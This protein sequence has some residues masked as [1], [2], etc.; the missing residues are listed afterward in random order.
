MRL[1]GLGNCR[2]LVEFARGPKKKA[3]PEPGFSKESEVSHMGE[4]LRLGG[5]VAY[6]AA[7]AV[8]LLWVASTLTALPTRSATLS[9]PLVVGVRVT[10]TTFASLASTLRV[11][12]S[13]S[14]DLRVPSV[15]SIFPQP[16]WAAMV[17]NA[18]ARAR[19]R[20][21]FMVFWCFGVVKMRER[22][23]R[24]HS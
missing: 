2:Q 12:V 4:F 11:L 13:L 18:R 7:T 24:G 16:A 22:A 17:P 23:R 9:A 21:D 8:A 5:A 15:V 6:L 20:R 3:R 1:E 19:E 10:V 14:K